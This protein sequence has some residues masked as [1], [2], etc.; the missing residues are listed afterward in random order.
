M[1]RPGRYRHTRTCNR[2]GRDC[3][4]E[5]FAVCNRAVET[6]TP[7]AHEELAS[8]RNDPSPSGRGF[9]TLLMLTAVVVGDMNLRPARRFLFGGPAF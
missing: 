2:H 4:K 3:Q 6:G 7:E 5:A 9:K 1:G 8:T